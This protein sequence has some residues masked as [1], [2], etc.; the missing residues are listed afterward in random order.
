MGL[1]RILDK[2]TKLQSAAGDPGVTMFKDQ[3]G[4]IELDESKI[5]SQEMALSYQQQI[6]MAQSAHVELSTPGNKKKGLLG[7]GL[8][9]FFK[10]VIKSN[11]KSP[12]GKKGAIARHNSEMVDDYIYDAQPKSHRSQSAGS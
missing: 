5:L 1:N 12:K 7:S 11:K 6:M 9:K 4:I 10:K 2:N 8:K 3:S